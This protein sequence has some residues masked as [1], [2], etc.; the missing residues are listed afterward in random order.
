MREGRCGDAV[1]LP[2]ISWGDA[3][4]TASLLCTGVGCGC[5]RDCRVPGAHLDPSGDDGALGW[6]N[7]RGEAVRATPVLPPLP[8][9][10][11]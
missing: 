8:C 4:K 6:R 9:G 1:L 10:G 7:I 2:C 11:G 3:L 5:F